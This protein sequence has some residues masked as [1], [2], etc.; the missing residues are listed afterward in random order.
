MTMTTTQDIAERVS[1]NKEPINLLNNP[2]DGFREPATLIQK[3]FFLNEHQ[4]RGLGKQFDK[5]MTQQAEELAV[6]FEKEI[7]EA[8]VPCIDNVKLSVTF[9]VLGNYGKKGE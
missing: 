4:F 7:G 8:E 2:S 6:Q 5:F 3:D 1:G 9:T